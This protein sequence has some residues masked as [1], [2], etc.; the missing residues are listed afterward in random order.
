MS[1]SFLQFL[2]K[3]GAAREPDS[4]F[5]VYTK[6]NFDARMKEA[7]KNLANNKLDLG[8]KKKE[9]KKTFKQFQVIS[10]IEVILKMMECKIF[11]ILT[12]VKV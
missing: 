2:A 5:M 12:S 1:L 9:K 6:T 11:S 8:D 3:I 7:E 10:F 4:E